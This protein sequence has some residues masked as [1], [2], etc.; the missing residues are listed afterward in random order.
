M[1][2]RSRVWGQAAGSVN[3]PCGVVGVARGRWVYLL[4]GP[5]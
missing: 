2:G 3:A 5:A 1:A 4:A